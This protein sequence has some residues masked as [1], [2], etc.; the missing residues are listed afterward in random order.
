[1]NVT[2]LRDTEIH[3]PPQWKFDLATCT[4]NVHMFTWEYK[5]TVAKLEDTDTKNNVKHI[6]EEVH[7]QFKHAN[8]ELFLNELSPQIIDLVEYQ[9][10]YYNL[11]NEL[12]E[13]KLLVLCNKFL[14]EVISTYMSWW[15]NKVTQENIMKDLMK[16]TNI[17][18]IRYKT[19]SITS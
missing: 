5:E 14:D 6:L 18:L 19:N 9:I 10:H 2:Q 4:N 1:M 3:V 8:I 12:I 15:I 11:N 7:S 13:D 17:F 16:L